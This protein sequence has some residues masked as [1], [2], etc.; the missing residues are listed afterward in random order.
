M[1]IHSDENDPTMASKR[2]IEQVLKPHNIINTSG[3][4][5]TTV[6]THC[7]FR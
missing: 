7:T 6:A 1:S 5:H 2:F 4:T 3:I